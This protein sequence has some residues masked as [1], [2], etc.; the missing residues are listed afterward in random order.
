VYHVVVAQEPAVIPSC[1][2]MLEAMGA[3][4]KA[5]KKQSYF[6]YAGNYNFRIHQL[7]QKR[8]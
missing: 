4:D 1:D 2:R 8:K 6:K 5:L 7:N 3:E